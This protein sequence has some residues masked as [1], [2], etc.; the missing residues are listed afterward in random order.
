[1]LIDTRVANI[2][3]ASTNDTS[4]DTIVAVANGQAQAIF[5]AS[6][7]QAMEPLNEIVQRAC[8]K[9]EME[10]INA[11]ESN[12]WPGVDMGLR[13]AIRAMERER[14]VVATGTR[15]KDPE[16]P[17]I[18]NVYSTLL[19]FFVKVLFDGVS[20]KKSDGTTTTTTALTIKQRV[21]LANQLILDPLKQLVAWAEKHTSS[22]MDKKATS[23]LKSFCNSIDPNAYT[24][25]GEEEKIGEYQPALVFDILYIAKPHR[26]SWC[27]RERG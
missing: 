12:G 10:R 16:T 2:Q 19:R 4:D 11:M 15:R 24:P 26:L 7:P 20:P 23:I 21:E 9:A 6:G 18:P 22:G 3:Q 8:A 27:S 17:R 1:M 5:H 13:Q 25:Q 14:L